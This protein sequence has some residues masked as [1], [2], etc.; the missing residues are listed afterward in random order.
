M[1]KPGWNRHAHRV[2]QSYGSQT[3]PP[4]TSGAPD[5]ERDGVTAPASLNDYAAT[6]SATVTVNCPWCDPP[7][8]GMV[9][10]WPLDEVNGSNVVNDLAVVNNQGTP[11]P[12]GP[13]GSTGAPNSVTGWVSRAENFGTG[14]YIEVADS[15]EINFG[16]ANSTPP[17]DLSMDCWVFVPDPAGFVYIHPIVDKLLLNP[18]GTL[19]I[20]YAWYHTLVFRMVRSSDWLIGDGVLANYLSPSNLLVPYNTWVHVGVTVARAGGGTVNFYQW[21]TRNRPRTSFNADGVDY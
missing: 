6:A 14:P 1:D 13:L 12:A 19:G 18:T 4:G 5:G 9:A 11:K 15:P 10:W 7:P 20:G 21:S 8:Y 17:G 16:A 2:E 3:F